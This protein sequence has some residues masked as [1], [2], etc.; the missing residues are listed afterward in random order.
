M[1]HIDYGPGFLFPNV[2]N[3]AAPIVNA[4]VNIGDI[5][6]ETGGYASGE[7][8]G[9]W[10]EETAAGATILPNSSGALKVE[11]IN[12][13]GTVEGTDFANIDVNGETVAPGGV[14]EV[15]T[16]FNMVPQ[17]P[18][19]LFCPEVT[20]TNASNSAFRYRVTSIL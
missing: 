8:V 16:K 6:I 17:P 19:Q 14:W 10:V 4:T 1:P 11:V 20:V 2:Y 13:G 3:Q 18:V 7:L 12:V 5:T 15:E 9:E